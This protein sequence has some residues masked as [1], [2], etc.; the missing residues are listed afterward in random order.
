MRGFQI[1]GDLSWHI[2]WLRL[3]KKFF[4]GIKLFC[5]SRSKAKTFSIC[6]KFNSRTPTKFKVIQQSAHSDN[7]FFKFSISCLIEW[8]FCDHETVLQTDA[9]SFN[10]LSWKTKK[11]LS[12]KKTFC[13]QLSIS[14]QKSF[15][16]WP[17]FHWRFCIWPPQKL[18]NVFRY[19]PILVDLWLKC[20]SLCCS[21]R[22]G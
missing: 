21:M 19:V 4:L 13:K 16:Y 3:K 1:H 11:F 22:T 9:E 10:F 5:F 2:K 6:L 17:N 8:K 12:L 18:F 7:C 15:V 14:K 20:R